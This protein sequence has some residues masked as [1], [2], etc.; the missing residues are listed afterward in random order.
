MLQIPH[1]EFSLRQFLSFI[2][3]LIKLS[4]LT[5][6]D[7]EYHVSQ[8]VFS[9]GGSA[10]NNP[11]QLNSIMGEVVAGETENGYLLNSGFVT[12]VTLSLKAANGTFNNPHYLLYLG[13]VFGGNKSIINI[14][15]SKKG[16][17]Q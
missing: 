3:P 7:S 2:L 11:Y 6:G 8:N 17:S 10:S 4:S 14:L 9:M 15:T 16:R 5:L 13:I 12:G 1:T